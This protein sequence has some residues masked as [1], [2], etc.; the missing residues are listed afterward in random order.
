MPADLNRMM[1]DA[2][3]A[4]T[5][6]ERDMRRLLGQYENL[7][8]ESYRQFLEER[9]ASDSQDLD[10]F[11]RLV[12]TVKRNRDV[13]GSLLR[14]INNLRSLSGFQVIEEEV[15]R[16]SPR[17]TENSRGVPTPPTNPVMQ[18]GN[19][20]IPDA[21]VMQAVLQGAVSEVIPSEGESHA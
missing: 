7:Y 11:H 13:V 8:R 2:H 6:L 3:D 16:R 20:M 5:A 1:V 12:Q 4:S 9:H 19:Q 10:N 18:D 15:E 21:D 14:G 17:R